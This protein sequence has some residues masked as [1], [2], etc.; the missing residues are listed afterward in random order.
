L[1]SLAGTVG[2]SE[3]VHAWLQAGQP[4]EAITFVHGIQSTQE[5][6]KMLFATAQ[7]MLNQAGA[8]NI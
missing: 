7:D 1:W 8:P 3:I 4:D 6:A 2:H 5:R